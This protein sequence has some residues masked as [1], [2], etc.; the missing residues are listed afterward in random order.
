MSTSIYSQFSSNPAR[1]LLG[2]PQSKSRDKDPELEVLQNKAVGLRTAISQT[3]KEIAD[4]K[5]KKSIVDARISGRNAELASYAAEKLKLNKE[6]EE[7]ISR[8]QKL[9]SEIVEIEED[10][11][12]VRGVKKQLQLEKEAI[13]TQRKHLEEKLK[14]APEQ[15]KQL[16]RPLPKVPVV[17]EKGEAKNQDKTK[18]RNAVLGALPQVFSVPAEVIKSSFSDTQIEAFGLNVAKNCLIVNKVSMKAMT[19][20]L[21]VH[22]E[23][24]KVN[25]LA[26]KDEFSEG[27][28]VSFFEVLP[29]TG[30][31]SLGMAKVLTEGEKAAM[32]N[33]QLKVAGLKIVNKAS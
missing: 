20:F 3:K 31:K 2:S 30:V 16:P 1:Q 9:D 23:V 7:L 27:S 12:H 26:F 28:L 17:T 15:Q 10:L 25:L 14:N 24:V 32:L 8:N 33:A 18:I 6:K 29:Q 22:K 4:L 11:D 5:E 19:D 21:K 13:Q